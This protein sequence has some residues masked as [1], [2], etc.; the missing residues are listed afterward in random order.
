MFKRLQDKGESDCDV[1]QKLAF[2]VQTFNFMALCSED[3]IVEPSSLKFL[4]E[5]GFD[6]RKQYSQGLPYYR[7]KDKTGLASEEMFVRDIFAEIIKHKKAI[8]L[9]N[10]FI[11][12]VFLYQNFYAQLPQTVSAFAADLSEMFPNGVYDTKYLCD[13]IFRKPSSF[14]EYVFRSQ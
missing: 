2:H 10:G 9:H 12:L 5:H 6:F 11:D 7:G 13:Y 14:L 8:V 1:R 3:Y 4:V